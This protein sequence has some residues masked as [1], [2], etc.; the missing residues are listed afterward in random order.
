MRYNDCFKILLI[1]LLMHKHKLGGMSKINRNYINIKMD[2]LLSP[3]S[4]F[5]WGIGTMDGLLF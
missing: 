2:Y 5:Q 4:R 1:K 3:C